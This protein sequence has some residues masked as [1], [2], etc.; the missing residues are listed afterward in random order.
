MGHRNARSLDNQ[1]KIHGLRIE[2]GEIETALQSYPKISEAV[3]K[4]FGENTDKYLAAYYTSSQPV[5]HA[6]LREYLGH[7]LPHCHDTRF[8]LY[9]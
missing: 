6:A 1:V 7:K 8:L 9:R 2:L 5:D 3:V 4:D